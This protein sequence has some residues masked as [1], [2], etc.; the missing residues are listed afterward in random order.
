M[1]SEWWREEAGFS[2][3]T[4][5][6]GGGRG[7]GDKVHIRPCYGALFSNTYIYELYMIAVGREG[8]RA[9][10]SALLSLPPVFPPPPSSHTSAPGHCPT[11]TLGGDHQC[12]S[13]IAPPWDA[14]GGVHH[15]YTGGQGAPKFELNPPFTGPCGQQYHA[16]SCIIPGLKEH[17]VGGALQARKQ[18][19]Y[20]GIVM[21]SGSE[22]R[23][24]VPRGRWVHGPLRQQPHCLR[25]QPQ[26]GC[27]PHTL[28]PVRVIRVSMAVP[29]KGLDGWCKIQRGSCRPSCC[30]C[31]CC[32]PPDCVAAIW[33]H[34]VELRGLHWVGASTAHDSGREE[35][36][37]TPPHG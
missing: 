32:A 1:T 25:N 35:A 15:L 21:V 19:A 13:A 8:G 22:S 27:L 24:G 23:S 18:L 30:C 33:V 6:G 16:S 26:Q 37:P 12:G 7:R 34:C 4:L 10:R 3:H 9:E 17:V 31:C 36:L 11:S 29:H 14:G 20:G 2:P 5:K 28:A